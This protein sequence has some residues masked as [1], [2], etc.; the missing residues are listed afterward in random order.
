M[1]AEQHAEIMATLKAL[2]K[3]GQAVRKE[4]AALSDDVQDL[5]GLCGDLEGMLHAVNMR[6]DE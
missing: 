5:T 1:T 6:F 2:A 3:Q 4:L